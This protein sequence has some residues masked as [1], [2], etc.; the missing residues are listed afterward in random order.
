MAFRILKKDTD[1]NKGLLDK[2]EFGFDDY[3]AGGDVGRVYIGTGS[4]NIALA[5]KEEVDSK[6][7]ATVTTDLTLNANTL[8]YTNTQGTSTNIDLSLYLDDTNLARLVNGVLDPTT[9]IATFTRDDNSTFTLDLSALLDDTT[10]T[11]VDALLSTATDEALSANQGR[12][13]KGMIDSNTNN[14]NNL[15]TTVTGLTTVIEW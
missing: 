15:T 5:T 9:G 8:T 6:L 4:S 14:I 10:V 12:V 7:P 11:V 13:L 2:A 3:T 1:G